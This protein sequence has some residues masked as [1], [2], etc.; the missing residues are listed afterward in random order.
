MRNNRADVLAPRRG[1]RWALDSFLLLP[2]GDVD[3]LALHAGGHTVVQ[4]TFETDRSAGFWYLPAEEEIVGIAGFGID[5]NT[6]T[7]FDRFFYAA[8]TLNAPPFAVEWFDVCPTATAQKLKNNKN[9]AMVLNAR[10]PLSGIITKIGL[11]SGRLNAG[12]RIGYGLQRG[13][14]APTQRTAPR[15]QPR[16]PL[17][18][19]S[20]GA[21][22]CQVRRLIAGCSW[23]QLPG[24]WS[25]R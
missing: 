19:A 25:S 16:L 12:H 3:G 8:G 11:K 20:S 23:R 5:Q 6:T 17:L 4:G 7:G 22:F 18:A 15:R 21:P 1:G 9:G 24:W 13:P 14:L 2:R 10:F